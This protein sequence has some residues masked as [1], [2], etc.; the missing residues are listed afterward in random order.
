MKS[1]MWYHYSSSS[2]VLS[3]IRLLDEWRVGVGIGCGF[4]VRFILHTPAAALRWPSR[5]MCIL[6]STLMCVAVN[7]DVQP[8]LCG[9]LN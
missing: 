4:V 8:G 2:L 9:W 7:V 5:T 3:V 6:F 1:V